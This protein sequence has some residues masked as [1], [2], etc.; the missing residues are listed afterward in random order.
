[1]SVRG[2]SKADL[3]RDY[4]R[5]ALKREKKSRSEAGAGVAVQGTC[6]QFRGVFSGSPSCRTHPHYTPWL[7]PPTGESW[8]VFQPPDLSLAWLWL[9]GVSQWMD[10]LSVLSL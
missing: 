6:T 10:N 7:L 4:N 9:W 1:M 5:M 8:V 3:V 2:M